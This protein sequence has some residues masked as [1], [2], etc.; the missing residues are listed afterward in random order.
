M[1]RYLS[2]YPNLIAIVEGYTDSYGNYYY[3]LKLSQLRANTIKSYFVGQGIAKSRIKVIGLGN[4]NPIG[5]NENQEGRRK[6]RRVEIRF[7]LAN[8]SNVIN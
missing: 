4:E 2:R 7:E 5:D 8:K 6:N 1:V 3:N